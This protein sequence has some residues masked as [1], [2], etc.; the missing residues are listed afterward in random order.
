[1][2]HSNN[3]NI[4]SFLDLFFNFSFYHFWTVRNVITCDQRPIHTIIQCLLRMCFVVAVFFLF[5][6]II[7]L[8]HRLNTIVGNLYN[9][10]TQ[11]RMLHTHTHKIHLDNVKIIWNSFWEAIPKSW[12]IQMKQYSKY[13]LKNYPTHTAH[14]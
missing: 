6:Y 4:V 14:I 5:Q 9:A 13:R 1:M 8:I 11:I 10:S 12:T 3:P 2:F 7:Y